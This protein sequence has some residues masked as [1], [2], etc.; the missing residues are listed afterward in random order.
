MWNHKQ[1][2][3]K[4]TLSFQIKVIIHFATAFTSDS[5]DRHT[6]PG[7]LCV[8]GVSCHLELLLPGTLRKKAPSLFCTRRFLL[9]WS[10]FSSL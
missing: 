7:K 9:L 4:N 10:L 1:T 3:K 6:L 8:K 5:P 2:D